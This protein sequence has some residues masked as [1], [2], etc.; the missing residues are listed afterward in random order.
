MSAV[1]AEAYLKR[2]AVNEA[3]DPRQTESKLSLAIDAV[4]NNKSH[5]ADSVQS[6]FDVLVRVLNSFHV[7]QPREGAFDAR[8][9]ATVD[10]SKGFVNEYRKLVAVMA[11]VEDA[12][13]YSPQ[14]ISFL[15]GVLDLKKN[16]QIEETAAYLWRD[17]LSF[18]GRELFLATMTPLLANAHWTFV[19]TLLRHQYKMAKSQQTFGYTAFD[20]FQRSLDVFRNR[21]LKL[22][23]LSVAADVLKERVAESQVDFENVMQTDFFLHI[24]SL[25]NGNSPMNAWYARTLGHADEQVVCGFDLFVSARAGKMND[26]LSHVFDVADWAQLDEKLGATLR[27]SSCGAPSNIDYAGYIA[28]NNTIFDH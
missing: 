27:Q 16:Y 26:G 18:I 7:V 17:A 6:Y 3:L 10:A 28:A 13:V 4:S 5:A 11:K 14:V 12:D 15:E 20:G 25:L 8:I 9:L 22:Q 1:P 19:R 23:R 21:R 2:E 24:N